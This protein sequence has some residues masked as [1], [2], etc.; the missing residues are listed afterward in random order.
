MR[1]FDWFRPKRETR[2]SGGYTAQI[3][4]G[5]QAYIAGVG[6]IGELTATVQACVSLWEGA[7]SLA[8]VEGA[9]M[10]SRH[11]MALTARALALRG[12]AVF[13]IDG[14]RLMPA[15]DWEVTTRGGVPRGYR[16]TLPETGGATTTT[17]L[18]GEVLHF[19]VAPDP[20]QPWTGQAPLRRASLTAGLL[21]QVETALAEVYRN[22]PIGSL[23][24]P[25][26]ETPDVDMA[27]L[28]RGFRGRRGQ[29]MLRES[30]AVT[31]AGGPAPSADWR[32]QDVTP[33]LQGMVP[34]QT[35]TAARG[36]IMA[37]FDVLPALFSARGSG[38][39]CARGSAASGA[40]G[41]ST[42]RHDDG[43]G[44]RGQAGR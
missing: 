15:S 3:I 26:P 25:F 44:S 37:A 12:E 33:D 41:A 22:A 23:V 30:V 34:M 4:A 1:L 40:M 9:P 42:R 38:A 7:L 43:R 21:Q 36:A 2:S 27:E 8:A 11:M 17:A 35:L 39:A 31:A 28:G 29:V 16:L 32:P 10:L 6:G 20:G 18:A 19:R 13:L 5:R 14:D 24:V